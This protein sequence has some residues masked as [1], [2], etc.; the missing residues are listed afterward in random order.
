MT[1]S[2]QDLMRS[3]LNAQPL[4]IEHAPAGAVVGPADNNQQQAGVIS[5]T[6]GGLAG[7]DKSGLTTSIRLQFRCLAATPEQVDR[8]ERAIH[9]VIHGR[10]RTVVRDSSGAY[11]LF[12]WMAINGGPTTHRDSDVTWE[13]LMY[14]EVLIGMQAVA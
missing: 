8:I 14:A 13:G 4:I 5:I 1:P 2:A 12:H 10:T 7:V 9:T 11:Y 3:Y 6:E